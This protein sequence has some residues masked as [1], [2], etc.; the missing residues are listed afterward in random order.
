MSGI[1]WH[2]SLR[3]RFWC[4]AALLALPHAAAGDWPQWGG[5]P[6]HQGAHPLPGNRSPR[7]SPTRTATP[8]LRMKPP[9]AEAGI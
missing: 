5:G 2:R 6:Q 1:R 3:A 7:S 4:L 9:M 8:S